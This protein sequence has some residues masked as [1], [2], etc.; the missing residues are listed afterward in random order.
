MTGSKR[1]SPGDILS[2]HRWLRIVI[3]LGLLTITVVIAYWAFIHSLQNEP[4]PRRLHGFFIR[5]LIALYFYGATV[6][7]VALLVERFALRRETWHKYLFIHVLAACLY[8]LSHTELT[9]AVTRF[10]IGPF[11]PPG[12]PLPP[13]GFPRPGR[14]GGL[15]LRFYGLVS[16]FGISFLVYWLIATATHMAAYSRRLQAREHQAAELKAQLAEVRL[17]VLKS[18]LQPHFLFNTLHSISSL[19]YQ[20]PRAADKMLR[21]LSDLLRM[22]LETSD[23]H[24]VTLRQ[25]LEFLELYLEIMKTRYGDRLQVE[26]SVQSDIYDARV[27]NLILQPFVENA[28]KHGLEKQ[29]G[30]GLVSVQARRNGDWLQIQ[31]SDSGAGL[32]LPFETA[33]QRG[34][35]WRNTLARL[36]ALYG[37][38]HNL[39]FENRPEGGLCVMLEI[40]FRQ[41][42]EGTENTGA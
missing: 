20:D 25:E 11:M 21:Q 39:T 18:Q 15:L 41:F 7:F 4:F 40:P 33:V 9:M 32:A 38:A 8:A 42:R 37:N 27:P 29:A 6:P 13:R 30:F 28:I 35:G 16:T 19:I 23:E 12:P 36:Q 26:T 34:K 1:R 3:Y 5:W 22:T 14:N 2:R 17:K 24:E 10:I 31:I